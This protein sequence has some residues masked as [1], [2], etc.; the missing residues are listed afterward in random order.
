MTPHRD[1]FSKYEKYDGGDVFLG[2]DSTT[3]ILGRGRVKLLLKYGRIITL[4]RVLHIPKLSRSLISVSKLDDAGVDTLFGKNTCKMV[5]GA[6][7]LIRGVRCGTLYK[8]L[9]STYT[10]G[11]N[12]SVVLEQTNKEDKTNIVPKKKTMLWHQRLGHI[13]EKGLRTLHNK[14][15]VEGMSN[16]TMDFDFR[17]HCIYG[18]QNRVRFPS[19]ATRAKGILE[20]IH[21]DVF[22]PVSIPSLGKSVYY[23]SFIDDFSS[24]TWIYFPRKKSKVFDKFKEFKSLVEN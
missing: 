22:G 20:L 17:E 1:W 13:G 18:K 5:R 12:S 16:C 24:Y 9:G 11:C 21:S 14:G 23:V 6:M 7:V 2:D 15:M 10:N 8:L 4:P 19:G 3:K